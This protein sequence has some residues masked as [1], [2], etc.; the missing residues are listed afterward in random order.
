[1]KRILPEIIKKTIQSPAFTR[2][3]CVYLRVSQLNQE[4]HTEDLILESKTLLRKFHPYFATS[5]H[6]RILK[7]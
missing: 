1:M 5:I 3:S 2:P 6:T 7:L 4:G